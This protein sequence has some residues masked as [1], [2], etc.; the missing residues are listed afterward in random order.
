MFVQITFAFQKINYHIFIRLHDILN[1]VLCDVFNFPKGTAPVIN[2]LFQNRFYFFNI[3]FP[4][5]VTDNIM[6][7]FIF[8]IGVFDTHGLDSQK[9]DQIQIFR[10]QRCSLRNENFIF[11]RY[12]R[13]CKF[14]PPLQC[15][16]QLYSHTLSS[17]VVFCFSHS[18]VESF[19][20][21]IR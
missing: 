19:L 18:S 6:W 15:S 9:G 12:D 8:L 14:L 7:C 4:F 11:L 21:L 1:N 20:L 2:M 17:F 3:F 16:Y 10:F 13:P 5:F